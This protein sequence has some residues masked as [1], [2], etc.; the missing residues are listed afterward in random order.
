MSGLSLRFLG[1]PRIILDG[2]TVHIDL[3][4]V[5]A[6]LVYLAVTARRC[7]RDELAELFYGKRN[8]ESA[9]ANLRRTLSYLRS[10]IGG[11]RLRADRHTVWMSDEQ[12]YTLDVTEYLSLLDNLQTVDARNDPSARENRLVNAVELYRGEFLSGFFLK[13]SYAFEEWQLMMHENLRQKQVFALKQLTEIHGSRDQY[14]LAIDYGRRWVCIDALNEVAHRWLMQLY[15]LAGRRAEAI[16]Q[17]EVCRSVLEND[18][19]V[20]PEEETESLRDQIISG[21]TLPGVVEIPSGTIVF[22]FTDI[23][24]TELQTDRGDGKVVVLQKHD[25]I[26]MKVCISNKGYVFRVTN[27]AFCVAFYTVS[28]ALSAA[29]TA[30][31]ALT[32]DLHVR[33]ALHAGEAVYK[34]NDYLGQSVNRITE[35]LNV[36]H[37]GQVLL[38]A[39]AA[40]IGKDVLPD[41]AELTSLGKFRLSD[42][43][44]PRELYQLVHPDL[45]TGFSEIATLDTR[46]N[47]LPIQP[48]PLI[49]RK[50]ELATA[51]RMLRNQNIRLMT[52]TGPGGSGKT[53]LA[54]QIA[55]D[56]ISDFEQGAY[57]ID[58]APLTDPEDVIR[59]IRRRLGI[60][61]I[62]SEN[63]SLLDHLKE[64]LFEKRVLLILDNFEH[65]Q[66]ASIYVT[67]LISSCILLKII[68]TSRMAL[69]VRVEHEFPVPPLGVPDLDVARSADK[70]SRYEAA[71]LF[72]DRAL[73]V[74]PGFAVTNRNAPAIADICVRLDGLPLAIEL[75][76]A[77][78]KAFSPQTILDHLTG[79]LQ[80]LKGGPR[81][82][83]KRQQTLRNT[84]DWSYELLEPK[85]KTLLR[86]L[87]VFAGSFTP[88]RAESVSADDRIDLDVLDGLSSLVDMN[89]LCAEVQDG[90]SRYM[91]LQTIREYAL[92]KLRES[93]EEESVFQRF[94]SVYSDLALE[95]EPEL[96][97]PEQSFWFSDLESEY[98]NLLATLRILREKEEYEK[99]LG[100]AKSLGWFW[101]RR[102]HYKDG[103]YWLTT[104]LELT[105][106]RKLPYLKAWAFRYLADMDF[107]VDTRKSDRDERWRRYEQS[108]ALFREA[109][110][111]CGE[112]QMLSYVCVLTHKPEDRDRRM[113]DESVRIARETGDAWT[114]G[115]CILFRAR[116]F[117][118]PIEYQEADLKE[119]MKYIEKTGDAFLMYKLSHSFEILYRSAKRYGDAKEW[120]C[121]AMELAKQNESAEMMSEVLLSTADMHLATGEITEAWDCA[122]RALRLVIRTG[123][124]SHWRAVFGVLVKVSTRRSV[125]KFSARLLGMQ[126]AVAAPEE[127]SPVH[128]WEI[129]RG[130][131]IEI[132]EASFAKEWAAGRRM[133]ED[134]ILRYISETNL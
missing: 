7:S 40:E 1:S 24:S 23:V 104:Y 36:T 118:T 69:H 27:N 109:G 127:T 39:A 94:I 86:R 15:G 28:N 20:Q 10:A 81:D 59:A 112:A 79:S 66:K 57:F 120:L 114:I 67:E 100:V 134:E 106:S 110:D 26:L 60:V 9:R 108:L 84:I 121:R 38:T 128:D 51:V 96:F 98:A 29:L 95:A 122:D 103:T 68:I 72:I 116:G 99:G 90:R 43:G 97:G 2:A 37:G 93:G 73:A 64:Y 76:T 12:D 77:R 52:L 92:E 47:S 65:L 101:Y 46:P 31:L 63:T 56:A 45:T 113:V 50:K 125:S 42:L 33:M 58:L 25:E 105:I 129:S 5:L 3:R 71:R 34:D 54:L 102:G 78:L 14:E 115:F 13:D 88:E 18:L 119:A 70:V 124:K 41:R 19:G 126:S 131:D 61:D 111:R 117:I 8:R 82:L 30:Q 4:K 6:L 91:M 132:D 62:S 32:K 80:F 74:K 22:L 130:L 48:T 123:A 49:G 21:K 55:A 85:E 16:R 17:Y 53:R 83:P 11:T 44:P 75:A 89:L 107:F 35:V 133:T 87:S